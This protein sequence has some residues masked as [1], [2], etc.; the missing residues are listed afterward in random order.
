MNERHPLPVLSHP[1]QDSPYR[2]EFWRSVEERLQHIRQE[3][4]FPPGAD[5]LDEVGR[6]DFLRLLGASM[7]LAGAACTQPPAQKLVPYHRTPPEV[8]PGSRLHFATGFSLDG[9]ALGLLVD[10]REG[11]PVKIEGNPQHPSSLGASGPLEQAELLRLYDPQRA[12]QLLYRR[13]PR[14]WPELFDFISTRARELEKTGGRGLVFLTGPTSSP[15]LLWLRQRVKARLPLAR[16]VSYAAVDTTHRYQGAAL[17]FGSP[18][19]TLPN[20]GKADVVVSFDEDF[21]QARGPYLAMANAYAARRVPPR[22]NRLYMVESALSVTGMAADHRFAVPPTEVEGFALAL[23]R[24]LVQRGVEALQPIAAATA[25]R[26]TMSPA[27][28]VLESIAQDLM[29]AKE[30]SLVLAG[31][32]QPA[33]VNALAHAMNGALRSAGETVQYARP[34]VEDIEHGPAALVSLARALEAGEVRTLVITTHNP[35]YTAPADVPFGELLAQAEESLYLGLYDDETAAKAGWFLPALHWLEAWGD[36]RALDGTVTLQQPLLRPLWGGATEVELF[37]AFAGEEKSSPR[38]LLERVHGAAAPGSTGAARFEEALRL[39]LLPGSAFPRELPSV[40]YD[41]VASAVGA[42]LPERTPGELELHLAPDYKVFDGRYANNPWLQEL[43]DPV[44][45]LTWD[46]AA[47]LGPAT[48]ARLGLSTQEVVRLR[49]GEQVV[50]APV[51]V[52]PGHA[53]D[54]VTL[55]L[56]YG[57]KGAG[58]EIARGVGVDAYVLR[59]ASSPWFERGL[60]VEKTGR[61]QALALTQ[62]HWRMEGR[63]PVLVGELSAWKELSERV[64]SQRGPLPSLLTHAD[65]G[66]APY[67]WAMAVDLARCTGCSACVLACQ[68][69]NNIPVVGK[70]NVLKNREMH[71]LRIDR[72]FSGPLESPE[73]VAQPVACVHCETAPCEYVCPVNATVHSDEG[74]NEMVYN[75][76]VGTRYCSNNCPYKVRRFNYLH[77]AAPKSPTEAMAMNPDVTVRARGVME[78]CTYCVQRIQRARIEARRQGQPIDTSK[79]V[80]ACQQACPTTAIVFGSLHEPDSPVAKLHRDERRYDLLHELGTRPRTAYLARIRNPNPGLVS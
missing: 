65:G 2:G 39:G 19:E 74:L 73:V 32:R 72:Y 55:P 40:S 16:F 38:E 36:G 5:E 44:T 4:E 76:C 70:A 18:K 37:A 6:R 61:T 33:L 67:Q 53:E 7:A 13:R 43:P 60:S 69:E 54:T 27:D 31:A 23:A 17:A 14:A 78:K 12:R 25:Q 9:L 71:W 49:L 10:S 21:L 42:G 26:A 41:R 35:V 62:E 59:R 50:E 22:M 45:K 47:L 64:H 52:V 46:N 77:Y 34:A 58:E 57:R 56:G 51:L 48:T 80:T 66:E 1:P 11:R 79:L 20:L 68:A 8:T 63:A 30:S 15:L 75:R 3:G 24:K 29:R 28:H